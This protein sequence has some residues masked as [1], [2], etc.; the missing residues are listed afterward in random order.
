MRACNVPGISVAVFDDFRILWAKTYGVK[1]AG[2]P[3]PVTLDTLFQAGSISKP[4]T[5]LAVLH[6]VEQLAVRLVRARL[7][8]CLVPNAT[9]M[10]AK[11]EVVE[12]KA[13][14]ERAALRAKAQKKIR[15]IEEELRADEERIAAKLTARRDKAEAKMQRAT[16]TLSGGN[17]GGRRVAAH[18]G[19]KR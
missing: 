12:A 7:R 11:I 4:V 16:R 5:A 19:K 6:Y 2:K 3:D 18:R 10:R 1:E 14:S 9:K 13:E 15:K 17:E 8:R